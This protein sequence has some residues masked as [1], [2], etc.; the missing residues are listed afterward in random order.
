M[1][2]TSLGEQTAVGVYSFRIKAFAD[3]TGMKLAFIALA[4][5]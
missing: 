3:I 1:F 5:N 2:V 4:L